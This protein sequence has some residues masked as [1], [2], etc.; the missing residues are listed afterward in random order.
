MDVLTKFVNIH[1]L[2]TMELDGPAGGSPSPTYRARFFTRSSRPVSK[3]TR[4]GADLLD[5]VGTGAW[6]GSGI[7]TPRGRRWL[8]TQNQTNL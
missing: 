3:P 7:V 4:V 1:T 5:C 8:G 6:T 2:G